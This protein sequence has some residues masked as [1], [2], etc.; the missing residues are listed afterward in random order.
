MPEEVREGLGLQ[1]RL[2]LLRKGMNSFQS[3][4][5]AELV[6]ELSLGGGKRLGVLA[7]M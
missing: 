6:W 4:E 1:D 5:E 3:S 2:S 7:R